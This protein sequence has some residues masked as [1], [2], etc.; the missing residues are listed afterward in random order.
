MAQETETLKSESKFPY[1]VVRSGG[2]QYK[3]SEGDMILV[4]K[5][6]LEPGAKWTAEEVLMVVDK[7]GSLDIGKPL[8]SKAKVEFEVLQ[9][10]LGKKNLVRHFRRRQ[11]SIVSRGHRQSY[12]RLIVKSIKA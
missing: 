1:A 8:C 7:P 3:V 2:K 12:T 11:S 10:T 6:D 5:L 9:Q 4:E